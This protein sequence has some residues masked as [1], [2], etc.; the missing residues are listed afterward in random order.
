VVRNAPHQ[1]A[2]KVYIDY[3]LSREGQTA[4]SRAS[5]LSSLRT[6]VSKDHIPD[7]LVPDE[8]V[9]YQ[10]THLEKYVKLRK[11][12]VDFLNTVIRR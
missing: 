3:L 1:N 6:D 12:I 11:E 5:G 7:V 10:E 4:W 9:K 2:V 8:G